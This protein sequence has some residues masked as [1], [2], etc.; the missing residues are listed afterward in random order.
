MVKQLTEEIIQAV[1]HAD[2]NANKKK[3]CI[4]VK[5]LH[6]VQRKYEHNARKNIRNL[7]QRYC[8]INVQKRI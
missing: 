3:I 7:K 5:H 2:R 8:N 4:N 1:E 6:T